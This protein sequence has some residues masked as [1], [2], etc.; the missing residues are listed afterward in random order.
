[1][2]VFPYLRGSRWAV[3]KVP[4]WSNIVQRS[5]SGGAL[6]IP[7]WPN[8]PLWQWEWTYEAVID[9]VLSYTGSPNNNTLYTDL[10]M[11]EA[12]YFAQKGRGQVFAYQPPDSA[13]VN[14]LIA[15]PDANNNSE[16]VYTVGGIPNGAGMTVVNESV[17]ELNGGSI[18]QTA[19]GGA[20]TLLSPNTTAPYEG[21]VL[22]WT[23]PPTPPIKFSFTRFYRVMFTEDTQDYEQFTYNLWTLKSLKFEQVRVTAN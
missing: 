1:M 19:G 11:I 22:H 12:F 7:L 2:L 21:W 15:P 8:N 10:Q 9:K 16:L 17:Q 4:Q 5:V 6:L 23:S 14:Q 3:H 20:Y 18:T 13:V